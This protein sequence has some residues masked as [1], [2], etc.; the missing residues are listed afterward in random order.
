MKNFIVPSYESR[1]ASIKTSADIDM[2]LN[3]ATSYSKRI[4]TAAKNQSL[5]VKNE[6][7][8]KHKEAQEVVRKLR[9]NRFDIE[10]SLFV[11]IRNKHAITTDV[12]TELAQWL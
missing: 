11:E 6:L 12:Q 1:L 7:N 5:E 8:S 10:D 2:Q 4:K 9:L 3:R